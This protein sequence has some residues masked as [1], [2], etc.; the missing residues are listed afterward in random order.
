MNHA[1]DFGVKENQNNR[2][3]NHNINDRKDISYLMPNPPAVTY[4][5]SGYFLEPD[6]QPYWI[7]RTYIH[8]PN[9]FSSKIFPQERFLTEITSPRGDKTLTAKLFATDLLNYFKI[10]FVQDGKF[11]FLL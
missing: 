7:D 1:E 5:V 4:A 3:S 2:Q 6:F 8:I 10:V 11:N 9:Y